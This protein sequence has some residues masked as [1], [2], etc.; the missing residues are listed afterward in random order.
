MTEHSCRVTGNRLIITGDFS[1]DADTGFDEACQKLLS[2]GESELI[3]D[4]SAA[5]RVCSTYVGLLAELCLNAGNGGKT[6]TI[7]CGRKINRVLTEAGLDHAAK[8][9]ETG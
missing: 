5:T 1:A 3:V 7:R 8:L 4:L 9:Q 6:L 2:A